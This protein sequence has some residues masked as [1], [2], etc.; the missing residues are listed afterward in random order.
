MK[1]NIAELKRKHINAIAELDA[2]ESARPDE[3]EFLTARYA[4]VLI[5]IVKMPIENLVIGNNA[6]ALTDQEFQALTGIQIEH[7]VALHNTKE[8]PILS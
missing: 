1:V 3:V 2:I 5:D 6:F 7:A 4:S 8:N